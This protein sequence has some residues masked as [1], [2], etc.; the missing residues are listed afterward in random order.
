MQKG[1]FIRQHNQLVQVG[2][3]ILIGLLT[4]LVV[5]LFRLAIQKL[6]N[7]VTTCFQYFH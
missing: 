4:G 7:L 6:L 5:S 1:E 2:R 3:A